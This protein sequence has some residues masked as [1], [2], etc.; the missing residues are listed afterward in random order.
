M[1]HFLPTV[2]LKGDYVGHPFRGNQWT[3]AS[4]VS[5]SGASAGRRSK[6]TEPPARSLDEKIA[7]GPAA[8][9]LGRDAH[10][11]AVVGSTADLQERYGR[12]VA[13][14][15]THFA[16]LGV[17]LNIDEPSPDHVDAFYGALQAVEDARA[18]LD[19]DWKRLPFTITANATTTHGQFAIN[20]EERGYRSGKF[21]GTGGIIRISL[22]NVTRFVQVNA[23]NNGRL[24]DLQPVTFRDGAA[25]G[26]TI[27]DPHSV[28][29]TF[30]AA[31]LLGFER[32]PTTAA[33]AAASRALRA[34]ATRR[35]AYG[36]VIHEIGHALDK[37]MGHDDAVETR[38]TRDYSSSF[39]PDD[40]AAQRKTK[41]DF[42]RSFRFWSDIHGEQGYSLRSE[43][44]TFEPEF[45]AAET[46]SR[47]GMKDIRERFAETFSA[48]WLL[49][50]SNLTV[51]D[52]SGPDLKLNDVLPATIAPI[53]RDADKLVKQAET[54][55]DDASKW[56][57]THPVVLFAFATI[58]RR[59]GVLKGDYVGHPFRGNQWTDASGISRGRA[60]GP[61]IRGIAQLEPAG[62]LAEARAAGR[63]LAALHPDHYPPEVKTA[64]TANRQAAAAMDALFQK[65]GI[66]STVQTIADEQRKTLENDPDYAIISLALTVSA[67][68]ARLALQTAYAR[69]L[70][71]EVIE[72]DANGKYPPEGEFP[73]EYVDRNPEGRLRRT[74]EVARES[75]VSGESSLLRYSG[76]V[77]RGPLV[78]ANPDGT[79]TVAWGETTEVMARQ[80]G[81]ADQFT[82]IDRVD[83]HEVF[84]RGSRESFRD[85]DALRGARGGEAARAALVAEAA[86]LGIQL[87]PITLPPRLS[88]RALVAAGVDREE[89]GSLIRHVNDVGHTF[90]TIHEAILSE[91]SWHFRAQERERGRLLAEQAQHF[92]PDTKISVTAPQS[93]VMSILKDGR[94]KTQF[95]TGKSG[96]KNVPAIREKWEA[97]M[98]GYPQGT[99]PEARPIYGMVETDGVKPSSARGNEQ[100]GT[101]TMVLKDRVRE[102]TTTTRGDSLFTNSAHV[103]INE[104]ATRLAERPSTREA[105]KPQYVYYEAQIHG[106]V[107][108]ADIERVVIDTA[109][110]KDYEWTTVQPSA[111]LLKALDKAGIPYEIRD[112][113]AEKAAATAVG[114][115]IVEPS[116]L[117]K[118][119]YIG[120][121]FRGNQWVDSS[122]AGRSVAS[123]TRAA[124]HPSERLLSGV[125]EYRVH[126][127]EALPSRWAPT[128]FVDGKPTTL[129]GRVSHHTRAKAEKELV[130]FQEQTEALLAKT[131]A[132]KEVEGTDRPLTE[133]D[134]EVNG[135]RTLQR[136]GWGEEGRV[137]ALEQ[138]SRNSIELNRRLRSGE[139]A[140]GPLDEYMSGGSTMAV[141]RSISN[142]RGTA[143]RI[144]SELEGGATVIDRGYASTSRKLVEA[145]Q[146]DA[147]GDGIILRIVMPSGSP[148]IEVPDGVGFD[149][150]EVILPRNTA[151]RPTGKVTT[152]DEG[153]RVFDVEVVDD[154]D[155]QKALLSVLKGDYEGHPFRGNQWMDASGVS[156]GNA[157]SSP[158]QDRQ[159][160]EMRA[161][162]QSWEQIARTL[163]YANGGSVRRLAM[164]HE[165]RLKADGGGVEVKP[166]PEAE[167]PP[168]GPQT[169]Y[170]NGLRPVTSDPYVAAAEG[171]P[172]QGW[173]T[174]SPEIQA[175]LDARD[176]SIVRFHLL[177]MEGREIIERYLETATEEQ[178]KEMQHRSHEGVEERAAE[179]DP[180]YARRVEEARA[181]R[182]A[183]GD[184]INVLVEDMRNELLSAAGFRP[185]T[186]AEIAQLRADTLL[187][188]NWDAPSAERDAAKA[189]L[190]AANVSLEYSDESR[191]GKGGR[192]ITTWQRESLAYS[193]FREESL[194]AFG[195]RL[196]AKYDIGP[197]RAAGFTDQQIGDIIRT[198]TRVAA[199][200]TYTPTYFSTF[201]GDAAD[202]LADVKERQLEAI[203]AVEEDVKDSSVSI[204]MPPRVLAQVL[205][206]GR[207]KS[208]FETRKSGGLNDPQARQEEEADRFGYPPHMAV[209][210]RPVYGMVESGG[211]MVPSA[212]NNVQYGSA[213]VVLKPEVRERTTFTIG[214][215]LSNRNPSAP[216]TN[217]RAVP[218]VTGSDAGLRTSDERRAEPIEQ[219]YYEAQIH[220]G[221]RTSDIAYV[222]FE[223]GADIV[224]TGVRDEGQVIGKT[225]PPTA[226]VLK[227]LTKAGIPYVIVEAGGKVTPPV[228]KSR[229]VR[230]KP[231]LLLKGDFVGH[232]FRG[233]Q[234]MDANGI[235]RG[236]AGS[237]PDQDKQA[238]DL[239]ASGKS[240]EEIAKIMGYA[241]GGSVRRLAMRH[242]ARLK[243][244][245]AEIVPPPPPPPPKP[246]DTEQERGGAIASL[247]DPTSVRAARRLIRDT[248]GENGVVATLQAALASRGG[249]TE[250]SAEEREVLANIKDVGALLD[251]AI[252]AEVARATVGDTPERARERAD[253]LTELEG[254]LD[255]LRS[256]EDE[257]ESALAKAANKALTG[258][259]QETRSGQSMTAERLTDVMARARAISEQ[260]PPDE[261]TRVGA[262]PP[263]TDLE[264]LMD[265]DFEQRTAE[266]QAVLQRTPYNLRTEIVGSKSP[267]SAELLMALGI[268]QLSRGRGS[269]V[270]SDASMRD[271]LLL[272]DVDEVHTS[273]TDIARD[274]LSEIKSGSLTVEEAAA[275]T[276]EQIADR[277]DKSWFSVDLE[278]TK[279]V[280]NDLRGTDR[281]VA[282]L[283]TR[284]D[285]R[286]PLNWDDAQPV[287]E[288][289]EVQ[290]GEYALLSPA[291]RIK[292]A[293]S[294]VRDMVTNRDFQRA[295]QRSS[296]VVTSRDI[297]VPRELWPAKTAV[298]S[299]IRDGNVV[300]KAGSRSSYLQ[301][302]MNI[303]SSP[304]NMDRQQ[305][306]KV[307]TEATVRVLKAA[308][309]VFADP[310]K[311]VIT[312]ER[313]GRMTGGRYRQGGPE[314]RG[315]VITDYSE[316]VES[317]VPFLP[318]ALV[319]GS[320]SGSIRQGFAGGG[321]LKITTVS[322]SGV[323]RAHAQNGGR[324]SEGRNN[325]IIRQPRPSRNKAGEL[326]DGDRSTMLHET[327]HG[328]EYANP[329]VRYVEHL[330]WT[331]R[332]GG[333]PI[334]TLNAIAGGRAGYNSDEKGVADQ[335]KNVYAGKTYGG[336]ATSSYEIFT[337]GLQAIFF[338]DQAADPEHRA[339]VL[340]I[341]AASGA[342]P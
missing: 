16:K 122:G 25:A 219:R 294:I 196:L 293:G 23:G 256:V 189:R 13:E 183:R 266:V 326:R 164:R 261:T 208:Q 224:G 172:L 178:K 277:A 35:M 230:Y 296:E 319:D 137:E 123:S 182:D 68:Q 263:D 327:G 8:L 198:S 306:E 193:A 139:L 254:M 171:R 159:A 49:G 262:L 57:T 116:V 105:T 243:K 212:R 86:R 5:R 335:W 329:W 338:G 54:I 337:T 333:E 6:K 85:G 22:E 7:D 18:N 134:T 203:V 325:V 114:K 192:L 130:K 71:F 98:F 339:V 167:K 91:D 103:P 274:I 313:E 184:D 330:T 147:V 268:R 72:P 229:G 253:L 55:N 298:G 83:L 160:Y 47:Y 88:A 218:A 2:L 311:T 259:A 169:G 132:V 74:E 15:T 113:R 80:D 129:Q 237:T 51:I 242:E 4:G 166:Q 232:P 323:R 334:R 316:A 199:D 318:R 328:V 52:R 62:S 284:T 267:K 273:A 170:V 213:V 202:P 215:S 100:Y 153:R 314:T 111:A 180:D 43:V 317:I 24:S 260:L 233:N 19:L 276:D 95:E 155:V 84:G 50:R 165:S 20:N 32:N 194:D 205:N 249:A 308:G 310:N 61:I 151:L 117:I 236:G 270:S 214:D 126:P 341:L 36:V 257:T 291:A 265:L 58:L 163:G 201:R 76:A 305:A 136:V 264:T 150:D 33:T 226:S 281:V 269:I 241:N 186:P 206:E 177:E 143:D 209:E 121:P 115:R 244:P 39:L 301:T 322:S 96:G 272:G 79:V 207:Y 200:R 99:P 297:L 336:G 275:L 258:S 94:V 168:V 37:H 191:Q 21:I 89:I 250:L 107:R 235:S 240:W 320:M 144:A 216:L 45:A 156:R 302:V 60:G 304:T 175:R 179:L 158:D 174:F 290:K 204:T 279:R 238:Y 211:V 69:E 154:A 109:T 92:T 252:A 222:V 108:V 292:L 286:A 248:F 271:R 280:E 30:A 181:L 140:D 120:H 283:P 190:A 255:V 26:S 315:E 162:G 87:P 288:P 77:G 38:Y 239:R 173:L 9:R 228:G 287:N 124:G 12:T 188:H 245:V 176:E 110:Y 161:A 63:P 29:Q 53:L 127:V 141:Y 28:D 221:V 299:E 44:D 321:Q 82:N 73:Y 225:K 11:F 64:L 307:R 14:I 125:R 145:Q 152:D 138:Y 128:L 106:G 324:D 289:V 34:E 46:L 340:G 27:D 231:T 332:R 312:V 65:H 102:R 197:L 157:G 278:P 17:V 118:G 1:P 234:W 142:D 112:G 217:P 331:D 148:R 93:A 133:I 48:W 282:R 78:L 67:F 75:D 119:D 40:T 41:E 187:A 195:R 56:E 342:K 31:A 59:A 42:V 3:D 247:A 104:A 300:I 101:V 81:R 246:D 251:A 185:R 149:Q 146:M 227:S 90:L 135:R 131:T 70:G 303:L 220:G 210:Y 66:A 285:L 295:A 223:V 309:V 97:V 10:G